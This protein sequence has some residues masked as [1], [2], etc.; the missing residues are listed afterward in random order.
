[1]AYALC[2]WAEI[3]VADY[4]TVAGVA[5]D[6]HS[7]LLSFS[8]LVTSAVVSYSFVVA[9][10]TAE[11]QVVPS[12]HMQR[13]HLHIRTA[14]LNRE[15]FPVTVI[16]RMGQPIDKVGRNGRVRTEV[17]SLL[18]IE[19]GITRER[20]LPDSAHWIILPANFPLVGVLRQARSPVFIEPLGERSAG[21]GPILVIIACGHYWANSSEVRWMRNCRQ[22]LG[23][24]D[25]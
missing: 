1:F 6:D 19:D 2:R 20:Q 13:C 14:L 22:H 15:S 25:V 17:G 24:A 3:N 8:R 21:I 10:R 7:Q 18:K 9:Q 16:A 4:A 11:K 23:R 5:A 12:C